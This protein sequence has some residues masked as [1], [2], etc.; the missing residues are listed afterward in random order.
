MM[1]LPVVFTGRAQSDLARHLDYLVP[2][3]G[4]K[5]ARSFIDK[6]IDY[7]T[8][9]QIFP[10]RG[11]ARDDILPGLRIVGY[12]RRASIAFTVSDDRIIILRIFMR[13]MNFDDR[14]DFES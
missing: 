14:D 5:T 12:K 11:A 4:E 6:I 3:A 9:L 1:I 8:A 10:L 7:C 13:G 2:L